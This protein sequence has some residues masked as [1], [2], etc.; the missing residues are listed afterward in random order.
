MSTD[1]YQILGV[2]KDASVADLKKAYRD[3]AVKYHPDKNS[4]SKEA[5]EKFKEINAA[6]DVL[7]DPVKR[8]NYDIYGTVDPQQ[9]GFRTYRSADHNSIFDHIFEDVGGFDAFFKNFTGGRTQQK[10]KNLDLFTDLVIT[11]EDAYYG[12]QVPFEV[13][14]PDGGTKHLSVKIPPG[15]ENG[16]RLKMPGKGSQQNV[17]IPAGDLYLNLHIVEHSTFKRMGADLFTNKTISVVDAIL[18][19]EFEVPMIDGS[20]LKITIPAG[21]QPDQKL[22]LQQKGMPYFNS[23]RI[24]DLYIMINITIPTNLNTRQKE[25]IEDLRKEMVNEANKGQ[26]STD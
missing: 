12:K 6:Y 3:L 7:K 15:V 1:Y 14:M 23:K 11:L 19:K 24:G 21:T 18:G 25:I 13:E 17:N 16:L 4:G 26:P 20:T 5:E 2:S 9:Q 8:Q 22:R 10:P